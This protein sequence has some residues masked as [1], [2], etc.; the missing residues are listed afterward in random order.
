MLTHNHRLA[1]VACRYTLGGVHLRACSNGRGGSVER[2]ANWLFGEMKSQCGKSQLENRYGFQSKGNQDERLEHRLVEEQAALVSKRFGQRTGRLTGTISDRSILETFG[3]RTCISSV[4]P[5]GSHQFSSNPQ[6]LYID[7]VVSR[8]ECLAMIGGLEYY[9]NGLGV[10][11]S[12]GSGEVAV[13]PFIS[14]QEELLGVACAHIAEK[15]LHRVRLHVQRTFQLSKATLAGSL[16]TKLWP[17]AKD[18]FQQ[19]YGVP[20]VDKA[21]RL[22]YDISAVLYLNDHLVDERT[23]SEE[24]GSEGFTGGRFLFNDEDGDVA[25]L[26]K[27]GRLL[28]FR[29][30]PENLHRVEHVVHGYRY[31]LA[32]WFTE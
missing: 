18:D 17:P 32:L 20:H 14:A 6:R 31:T 22:S 8:S 12:D 24:D 27:A 23:N 30:G 29:S 21:N 5:D 10:N 4:S 1:S 28:L 26:P 25:V 9:A 13:N 16:L 11:E 7:N 19:T 15:C 3:D 2:I